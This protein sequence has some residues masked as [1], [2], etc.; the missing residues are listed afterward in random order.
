MYTRA[1]LV[2]E[3]HP[4]ALSIPSAAVMGQED[5]RFVYTVTGGHAHRTPVT[6]GVDDGKTAEITSGL[7][8][9]SAV[10]LVGRDTLVDGGAVKAAPV[11]R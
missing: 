10:V 5:K 1:T 11:Q 2:L 3:V 7:R 9:G 6:V 4:N 8:P